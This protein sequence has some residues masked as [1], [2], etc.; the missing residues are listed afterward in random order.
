MRDDSASMSSSGKAAA[1]F[2]VLKLGRPLKRL[3]TYSSDA[4][5][6][7]PWIAS[8]TPKRTISRHST[9]HSGALK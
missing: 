6:L 9:S 2:W 3:V 1:W 8:G 5:P 7:V 4:P